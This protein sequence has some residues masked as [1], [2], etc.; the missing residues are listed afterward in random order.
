MRVADTDNHRIQLFTSSGTYLTQWGA[1]G[2]GNGQFMYPRGVVVDG[3]GHVH[4]A[5]LP[6]L[7]GRQ[8]QFDSSGSKRRNSPS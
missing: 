1:Q 7:P 8:S 3:S 4:V 5:D 2:S 6:D